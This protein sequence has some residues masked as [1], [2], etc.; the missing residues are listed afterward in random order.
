MKTV[1]QSWIIVTVSMAI[2]SHVQH[3]VSVRNYMISCGYVGGEHP[4]VSVR[5]C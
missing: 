2:G 5:N 1:V 3:I 4:G